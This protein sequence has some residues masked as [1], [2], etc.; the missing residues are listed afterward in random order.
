MSVQ[1]NS[2]IHENRR[3]SKT[4]SQGITD[5]D[6]LFNEKVFQNDG[7]K[8]HPLTYPNKNPTRLRL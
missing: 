3:S 8:L 4:Y 7:P 6:E 5:I 1:A 2:L